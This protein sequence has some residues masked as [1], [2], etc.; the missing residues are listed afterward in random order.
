MDLKER[1]EI[2]GKLGDQLLAG[3]EYLDAVIHRTFYNNKWFTKDFQQRRVKAIAQELLNREKLTNW[4]NQS[5]I[6]EEETFKKVALI[7]NSSLPLSLIREVISV[8][9]TGHLS[10]IKLHKDDMFLYPCLLKFLKEINTK[11]ESHFKIVQ[12]LNDYDAVIAE[13]D[14]KTENTFQTYFGKKPHLFQQKKNSIAILDGTETNA[15][16]LKL[17]DDILMYF[18]RT[19]KSVSKLYLPKGYDLKHLLEILHEFKD[20]VLNN[21]YKNNF[22]Y[23]FSLYSLNRIPFNINGCVIL[24]ENE[25]ISSRI[26]TVHF[27]YYEDLNSIKKKIQENSNS[28]QNIVGKQ[29][30]FP[31]NIKDFGKSNRPEL[32]DLQ[33][34]AELL[35]LNLKR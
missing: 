27:E 8:F 34:F 7:P 29:I 30:D 2:L 1:I 33:Q 17:G 12:N 9:A 20:L 3:D 14:N 15:D 16:L 4:V 23:N 11:T 28:I 18:G 10:L 32:N 25:A 19:S 6:S 26:G 13:I 5:S 22:D 21:K 35:K 31:M 24:V